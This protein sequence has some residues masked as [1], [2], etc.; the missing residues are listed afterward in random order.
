MAC[1]LIVYSY[2]PRT[3]NQR[4]FAVATG[5]RPQDVVS[6]HGT[7]KTA[8]RKAEKLAKKLGCSVKVDR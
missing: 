4:M 3:G 5:D 6:R 7:Q 2:R 8:I 1:N